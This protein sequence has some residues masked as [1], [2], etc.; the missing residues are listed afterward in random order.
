MKTAFIK[1]GKICQYGE[2]R[3]G[4]RVKGSEGEVTIKRLI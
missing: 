2:G 4:W 1:S 3:E